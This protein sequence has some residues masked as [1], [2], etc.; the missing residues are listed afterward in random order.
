M[1]FFYE[2]V[3]RYGEVLYYFRYTPRG[4]TRVR[5]LAVI[6]MH[7]L[8]DP[9]LLEQSSSTLYVCKHGDDTSLTVV[10]V[11]NIRCV[12]AFVPF[13]RT[14][15]EDEVNLPVD[16]PKFVGRHFVMEK[17]GLDMVEMTIEDHFDDEAGNG[18]AGGGE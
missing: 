6:S 18:D 10:D 2:G 11:E 1:E 17:Y 7:G 14:F 8:P 3:D 15:A 4:H 5:T 16:D 12:I 9:R 13:P